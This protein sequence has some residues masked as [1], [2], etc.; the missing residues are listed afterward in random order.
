MVELIEP[1]S[2]GWVL[3]YKPE[4]LMKALSHKRDEIHI[5]SNSYGPRED[6]AKSASVMNEIFKDGAEN[7]SFIS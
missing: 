7:V 2:N 6:F 3:K 5:Y 4:W 1:D